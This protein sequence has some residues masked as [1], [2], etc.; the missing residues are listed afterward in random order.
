MDRPRTGCSRRRHRL[1]LQ[2]EPRAGMLVS[3]PSGGRRARS[4]RA[5]PPRAACEQCGIAVRA[6]RARSFR[7][8]A[9]ALRRDLMPPPERAPRSCGDVGARAARAV[10]AARAARRLERH[11]SHARDAAAGSHRLGARPRRVQRAARAARRCMAAERSRRRRHV[12]AY[13]PKFQIR[14]RGSRMPPPRGGPFTQWPLQASAAPVGSRSFRA[15]RTRG[16]EGRRPAVRHAPPTVF[17]HA[18]SGRR[19]PA[20]VPTRQVGGAARPAHGRG[21]EARES[22]GYGRLVEPRP[23]PGAADDSPR[24]PI[25]VIGRSFEDPTFWLGLA[26]AQVRTRSPRIS[27]SWW[28]PIAQLPQPRRRQPDPSSISNV[29]TP[30]SPRFG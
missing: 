19:S 25:R 5:A 7:R 4:A 2:L 22:R 21:S 8:T 17:A 23:H 18:G 1:I 28:W 10:R 12:D 14:R 24:K 3:Q 20:H 16:A 13:A 11:R 9:P 29:Q 26:A 27:E 30:K 15:A 6:Q